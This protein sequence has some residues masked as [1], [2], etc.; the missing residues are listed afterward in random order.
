MKSLTWP[1][2][3]SNESFLEPIEDKSKLCTRTQ[4]IQHKGPT[5]IN[6]WGRGETKGVGEEKQ[7]FGWGKVQTTYPL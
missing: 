2:S 7:N 4:E 5:I 3:M 6:A 1:K